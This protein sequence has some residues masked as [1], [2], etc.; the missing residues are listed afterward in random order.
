MIDTACAH[1]TCS[2]GQC[3]VTLEPMG[4]PTAAQVPGDCKQR[5]CDGSGH[6]TTVD[7]AS[8]AP[9]AGDGC[10]LGSCNGGTPVETQAP[11]GASCGTVASLTCNAGGLCGT[12][13]AASQCGPGGACLTWTCTDGRCAPTYTPAGQGSPGGGAPGDCQINAC[14]GDGGV[15]SVPY[16]ADPPPSPSPCVVGTCMNGVPT[17]QPAPSGTACSGTN[18][19]DGAGH[20]GSCKADADCGMTTVC[21]TPACVSGQCSGTYAPS[22][23]AT[24]QVTGDCKTAVCDGKGGVYQQETG[25]DPPP[26]A[27]HCHTGVCMG[28]T[29]GQEAVSI[30]TS[31]ACNTYTCDPSMG[32][33]DTMMPDGTSCG[34]CSTCQAGACISTCGAGCPCLNGNVCEC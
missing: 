5:V 18:T 30:P 17:T 24:Q 19:C 11:V 16:P 2:G 7:D 22:G 27:D 31:D 6:V 33:V 20:C 10:T 21:G 15:V 23:P 26:A 13:T 32:V 1:P 9:D 4:T 3:G 34:G 14:D 25:N 8:D 29:P 12:C 28:E